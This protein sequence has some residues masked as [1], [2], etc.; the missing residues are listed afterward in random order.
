MSG[1]RFVAPARH[2]LLAEVLHYEDEQLGL[3]E[4]FVAAVEEAALRASEFPNAGSPATA[5]T[6]RVFLRSFPFSLVYRAD[7]GGIVI[8]AVAHHAREPGY[9]ASRVQD[10]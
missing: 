8:F 10:R 5:N 9:W 1:I 7:P 3:G 2:E 4:R 6:R